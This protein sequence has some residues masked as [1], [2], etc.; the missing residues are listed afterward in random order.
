MRGDH[1]PPTRLAR[2]TPPCGSYHGGSRTIARHDIIA[3]G[4]SAGGLEALLTLVR[5]LPADLPAAIFVVVHTSPHSPAMLATILARQGG[6]PAVTCRDN[7]E[8]VSGTI[9]VAPPDF[10]LLIRRGYVELSHGPR[11]NHTRPAIDPMFRTAARAY[12]PRVVGVVLSGALGDGATGLMAITSRGGMAVVQDPADA[13][14]EG[15]PRAALE[16]AHVH[17]V[18]PVRDMP[19]LLTALARDEASQE[20]VEVMSSSDDRDDEVT[21]LQHRDI[22][23]QMLGERVDEPAVY[24]CPDCGGTLWQ[25]D[26]NGLIQFACHVGHRYAPEN[27]LGQMSDELEAALWRCV[28][29]LTEK[30][31]L[32]RQ[33][34]QRLRKSGDLVH[35]AR[36]EE[37][38][39]LDDRHRELVRALV[40]EGGVGQVAQILMNQP[41][42]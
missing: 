31:T 35:A 32:T 5:G 10:H 16:D 22:E 2:V 30:A 21:A 27:L 25:A 3:I 17:F 20:G 29:V 39:D 34:A 37:Q 12:G 28:R 18:V 42:E 26:Q 40:Q 24:T 23:A 8:I 13:L 36:V 14:V 15:M 1:W 33:L 19:A 7:L 41:G 4:A 6:L 9:Y 11:E 38:A